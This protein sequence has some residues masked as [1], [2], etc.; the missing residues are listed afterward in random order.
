M[1]AGDYKLTAVV[2]RQQLFG[3]R[4]APASGDSLAIDQPLS[5]PTTG[6]AVAD[7]L[8]AYTVP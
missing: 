2:D 1:H 4:L 5:V 6:D 8:A 3:T 7:V